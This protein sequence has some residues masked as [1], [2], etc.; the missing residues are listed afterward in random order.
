LR[1]RVR[2]T[3]IYGFLVRWLIS[4]IAL[5]LYHLNYGICMAMRKARSEV[6]LP[7]IVRVLNLV[8]FGDRGCWG[9]VAQLLQCGMV[10]WAVW[11]VVTNESTGHHDLTRTQIW[12]QLA[13]A[14]EITV[15]AYFG[16]R[17]CR[18]NR[19]AQLLSTVDEPHGVTEDDATR[20]LGRC[21]WASAAAVAAWTAL[22][23]WDTA[24]DYN[25]KTWAVN[26]IALTYGYLPM[27]YLCALWLWTNWLF[28]RVG[29]SLVKY[30]LT[31][32]SV[33]QLRAGAAVFELLDEMRSASQVWTVNHAVRT[34][35]AVV[36]AEEI[37]RRASEDAA[38]VLYAW[39]AVLF[40]IVLA[41]AAAPG[42][43]TTHFYRSVLSKLAEIALDATT[44]CGGGGHECGEDSLLPGPASAHLA[45]RWS[46]PPPPPNTPTDDAPLTPKDTP[47]ALMQRLAA[48]RGEKGMH[49]AGVPMT[50]EKAITVATVVFYVTRYF[51]MP[52]TA[53]A[54]QPWWNGTAVVY[55]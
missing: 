10:A 12:A 3:R 4:Q 54:P 32:G 48:V 17:F 24:L 19:I 27:I 40:L 44:S 2:F 50:V 29:C 34:V 16:F 31:A 41:T 55:P 38:D 13:F 33:A 25:T 53:P 39:A 1:F 9:W 28:W 51:A 49:F 43:V 30:D 52:A 8:L 7:C 26:M 37:L 35:T 15:N 5:L 18:A 20:A 22:R 42:Y 23:P 45:P 6:R 47:T 14:T 36:W 11:V 21:T 46:T